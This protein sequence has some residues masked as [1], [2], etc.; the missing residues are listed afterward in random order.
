MILESLPEPRI[1]SKAESG[2]I[3]RQHL[4]PGV[5]VDVIRPDEGG[6]YPVVIY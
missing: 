1:I 5:Q 6:V 4:V 3:L 2:P